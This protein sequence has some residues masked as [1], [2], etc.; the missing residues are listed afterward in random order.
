MEQRY[1][2]KHIGILLSVF[3]LCF[4]VSFIL[5]EKDDFSENENRYLETFPTL[6]FEKLKEGIFTKELENYFA[7]HFP[8]RD[9]FMNLRTSFEL[10]FGKT[11]INNIY[12]G[13]DGYFIEEYK[14][15]KSNKKIINQINRFT[16]S[17]NEAE[18]TFMLVPTA[19][20][21]Y[22][23]KLPDFAPRGKQLESLYEI[24]DGIS[25]SKI[26]ITESLKSQKDKY[27]LYY[28]L[29][30]HWTSYGSY[31]G[32]QEFARNQGFE[33]IKM[34]E[35][36]IETVTED[37]KGTIYS[38]VHDYSLKGDNIDLFHK[39]GQNLSVHYMDTGEK[40]NTL[41]NLDYLEQKDKYSLFLDNI[42]SITEI[43]NESIDS[44]DELILIKDSYGNSILP[45]LINH[46]KKIY[47]IDPRYYRESASMLAN[48]NP[49][50]KDVLI[51]YNMNTIDTDLGI[52]GI[53]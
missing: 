38:K 53:Y 6:T 44:E 14:I 4:S 37:F 34:E 12:I 26:D 39:D 23:D 50:I 22:E 28:R 48:E 24:Y 25:S 32:Y 3:I 19:I 27:P 2:L 52:G 42:H 40:T 43:I 21:V 41:Y 46:Y 16:D 9:H 30:H 15:P 8:L 51:L 1:Y 7:D 36:Q 29:D 5:I 45:F 20:T 49:N 10:L 11:K 17:I 31:I 18:V 35:F 13:S 47:V 33:V